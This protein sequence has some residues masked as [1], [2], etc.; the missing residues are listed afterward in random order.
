MMPQ[1]SVSENLDLLRRF[2]LFLPHNIYMSSEPQLLSLVPQSVTA[3]EKAYKDLYPLLYTLAW[4]ILKQHENCEEVI[5][6]VFTKLWNERDSISL[7]TSLKS[8]LSR[9]VI[10]ASINFSKRQNNLQLHH[11]RILNESDEAVFN[12][13]I[14][15]AECVALVRN[16]IA[17]LPEQCRKVFEMSRYEEMPHKEIADQLNIS[18]KTVQAHIGL[19]LKT[20]KEK[21]SE[22]NF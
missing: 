14:E 15:R 19:A 4:R 21:L 6:D 2:N 17:K 10:N 11:Q 8:Y 9:S 20:L 1:I 5:H 16:E 7:N 12:D 18:V 22:T 3:F 13:E